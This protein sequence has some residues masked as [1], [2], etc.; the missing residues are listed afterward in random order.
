MNSRA[1]CPLSLPRCLDTLSMSWLARF[2]FILNFLII[3]VIDILTILMKAT[4]GKVVACLEYLCYQLVGSS[5]VFLS[6]NLF[7]RYV[8]NSFY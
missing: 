6:A 1:A 4:I 2:T 7:A 3:T 5:W 8:I